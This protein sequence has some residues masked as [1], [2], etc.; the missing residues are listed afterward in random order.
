M[1]VVIFIIAMLVGLLVPSLGRSM[2]LANSTVCMQNLRQIG[3]CLYAYQTDFDGWLPVSHTPRA[4]ETAS[5]RSEVWFQKL[6]PTYMSD[7]L[8][9]TCPEDPFRFRMIRAR[10]ELDSPEVADYPSYGINS[11]IMTAAGGE[12]AN[13]DRYRPSRPVNTILLADLGPD[14]GGGTVRE[15]GNSGTV[16]GPARN[17]SLL[18]LDDAFDI[19][20]GRAEPWLTA[21][22]GDGINI[23]TMTQ[24]VQKARTIDILSRLPQATYEDCAAGGCTLCN[25]LMLIHYS[26]ARDR[27]Y[28]W[29]GSAPEVVTGGG[30]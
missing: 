4:V 30:N 8:V 13:L 19:Y 12:L 23:L 16:R 26:F 20:S 7:P 22:H 27:L 17:G 25:E 3:Q 21:R 9:L 28:W 14:Y 5:A 10:D 2:R 24:N 18:A 15:P 6:W 29:T 1:L 11:F